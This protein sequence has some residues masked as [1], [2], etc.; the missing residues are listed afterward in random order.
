MEKPSSSP[1]ENVPR[2]WSDAVLETALIVV[3]CFVFGGWPAP[4]VNEA[5]YLTKAKHYWN[6]QF[7]PGDHFLDSADAHW[8]FYWS[9]GWVTRFVSLPT[10]A[11]IGRVVTWWLLAWSWGRLSWALTPR[12]GLAV[13]TFAVFACLVQRAL[14][15]GEWV[16]GGVEAKGFA[17][18]LVF[19]G[20]EA[21]IRRRW[22]RALLLLGAAT[23]VHV[24]T[25]GWSLIACTLSWR[26]LGP[27]RPSLRELYPAAIGAGFLALPGV[28]PGLLLTM[29]VDGHIVREANRIYVYERLG[30]HLVFHQIFYAEHGVYAIRFGALVACWLVMLWQSSRE[31][32]CRDSRHWRL[33]GFVAGSVLIAL[34]GIAIDQSTLEFPDVGAAL[35]RYYWFRLSDVMVPLGYALSLG[36]LLVTWEA[37][38]PGRAA[39]V[40]IG[41]LCLVGWSIGAHAWQRLA[42]LRPAAEIQAAPL[43][44]A[45][46]AAARRRYEDWVR[47]CRW[48]ARNTPAAARFLTP[49]TQQTFKWYAERSEVVTGK[50]VPQDAAALVEWRARM[51]AVYASTSTEDGLAALG[52]GP[53][54]QLAKVYGATHLI[55]ERRP[56][57]RL[58]LWRLYPD[59]QEI[60]ESFEI[61]AFDAP[62]PRAASGP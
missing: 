59:F 7:C 11:W 26:M 44:D 28:V 8:V 52:E 25:G 20:L 34:L 30:H 15:A 16:V 51:R 19:T 18:A 49:R 24:L 55:I 37:S 17:F 6:S 50:D 40:L 31:Q 29:G 54:R 2:T 42:D 61:Y 35:L 48:I 32:S 5:H 22:S 12:R 14:F 45:N 53:L 4:D 33:Q 3:V 39:W 9:F 57:Q 60:N 13:W 23:A 10:T 41:T 36:R 1:D 58:K 46:P 21:W 43:L 47:A 38:R 56:G 27:S 62:D